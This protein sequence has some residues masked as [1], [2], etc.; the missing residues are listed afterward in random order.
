MLV[1]IE[2]CSVGSSTAYSITSY[3]DTITLEQAKDLAQ[4]RFDQ[5][6]FDAAKSEDGTV[7][8]D[9]YQD[10]ARSAG[11][12]LRFALPHGYVPRCVVAGAV[13]MLAH[14][15]GGQGSVSRVVHERV[16]GGR[17]DQSYVPLCPPPQPLPTPSLF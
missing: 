10:F 5:Q 2:V 3:I 13:H 9:Q 12:E 8:K 1:A 14:R 17:D 4:E 6:A 16:S 11:V 7:T 15:S